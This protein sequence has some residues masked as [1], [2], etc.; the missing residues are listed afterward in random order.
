MFGI[1]MC[2]LLWVVFLLL[3]YG[4]A[5]ETVISI[6]PGLTSREIAELLTEQELIPSPVLFQ[7]VTKLMGVDGK[8]KAGNYRLSSRMG[9]FGIVQALA[10]GKVELIRFTIP[11]GLSIEEIGDLLEAKGLASKE[12]FVYLAT[13][14]DD[15]FRIVEDDLEFSGNLED[16]CSR[17]HTA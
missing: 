12:R 3:P 7:I 2:L 1:L 15:T 13:G 11:E 6:T 8:L 10:K 14:K 4:P 16:T 17:T 9:T 5:H